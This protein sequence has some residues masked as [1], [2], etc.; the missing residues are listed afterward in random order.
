LQI[1]NL[2]KYKASWQNWWQGLQP[3]WRLLDNGTFLQEVPDTVEDWGGLLQGG[4]NGFFVI[5]VAFSWW[6]KE[7]EVDDMELHNALDDIIWVVRTSG[8]PNFVPIR[9]NSSS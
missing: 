3:K 1:T 2:A 7:G 9:L 8:D 6:V 4:P 5:V